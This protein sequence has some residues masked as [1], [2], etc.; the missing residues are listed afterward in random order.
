VGSNLW[1][2]GFGGRWPRPATQIT[3]Q[4]QYAL[5]C[6]NLRVKALLRI[7]LYINNL[8]YKIKSL[9]SKQYRRP[10]KGLRNVGVG[11]GRVGVGVTETSCAIRGARGGGIGRRSPPGFSEELGWAGCGPG[12]ATWPLGRW[13]RWPVTPTGTG[14]G[15]SAPPPYRRLPAGG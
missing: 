6:Y 7:Q 13:V 10:T 9:L 12:G 5:R 15:S 2:A 3:T 8:L 4:S 11:S 14:A 1:A